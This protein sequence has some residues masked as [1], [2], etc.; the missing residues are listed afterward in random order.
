MAI[1]L[2]PEKLV[3]YVSAQ[4]LEFTD[5]WVLRF[6]VRG[7]GPF[8][9]VLTPEMAQCRD[10]VIGTLKDQLS[11]YIEKNRERPVYGTST[12]KYGLKSIDHKRL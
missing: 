3:A 4:Y 2:Q 1:V 12:I 9:L 7:R 5:R 10:D 8:N 6:D 11:A